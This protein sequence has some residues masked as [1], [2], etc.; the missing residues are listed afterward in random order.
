MST[1]LQK[2]GW[3]KMASTKQKQA[4]ELF[5][6]KIVVG[7]DCWLWLGLKSKDGYGIYGGG[8][9]GRGRRTRAH[10]LAWE[11]FNGCA[12]PPGFLVLHSCDNPSCVNPQHL[13]LGNAL[14]NAQDSITRG[15]NWHL[16]KETCSY[17]HIYDGAASRGERLCVTC[18]RRTNLQATH[19][20]RARKRM[21]CDS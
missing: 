4:R 9:H 16:K 2:I 10:R 21:Q 19:K 8:S 14:D 6:S 13:R 3:R 7:P 11:I 20:Y 18:T 5:F 17:G 1:R 15:R 12:I